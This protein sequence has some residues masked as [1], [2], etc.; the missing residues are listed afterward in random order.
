ME[1]YQ[2]LVPVC[3]IVFKAGSEL[4][5]HYAKEHSDPIV[6]KAKEEYVKK[7]VPENLILK[8]VPDTEFLTQNTKDLEEMLS[9]LPTEAL[10][11]GIEEFQ[12]D[13]NDILNEKTE[14]DD[15]KP[16]GRFQ[17]D[18]CKFKAF[19][20]RAMRTHVKFVTRSA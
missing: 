5:D 2:C 18:K 9:A 10:Y 15:I 12:K 1:F 7:I 20:Q 13:F 14:D 3:G 4:Q 17:C 8:I 6:E 16:R 19:S 11:T